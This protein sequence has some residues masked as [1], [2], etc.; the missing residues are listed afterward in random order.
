MDTDKNA[1]GE[2]H[3]LGKST[4][5]RKLFPISPLKTSRCGRSRGYEAQIPSEI[6]ACLETPHVVSYLLNE[7]LSVSIRVHPWL[8]CFFRVHRRETSNS[9]W[10][11]SSLGKSA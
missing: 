10:N 6:E 4:E 2:H 3:L 8:N 9:R 5:T 7:L 11:V 1:I